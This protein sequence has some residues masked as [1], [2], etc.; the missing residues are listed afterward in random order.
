[1]GRD[2]D[3]KDQNK[4]KSKITYAEPAA[5]SHKSVYQEDLDRRSMTALPPYY[6]SENG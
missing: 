6:L 5:R 4:Q 1:M 3:L 2:I